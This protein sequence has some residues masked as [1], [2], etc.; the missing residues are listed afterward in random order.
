[1][2]VCCRYNWND[3]RNRGSTGQSW[4]S[5]DEP[6][7]MRAR[8]GQHAGWQLACRFRWVPPLPDTEMNP[9]RSSRTALRA[10]LILSCLA[11][12]GVDAVPRALAQEQQGG[13]T[14]LRGTPAARP[15]EPADPGAA[16]RRAPPQPM[17]LPVGGSTQPAAPR[18]QPVNSGGTIAPSQAAT[19]TVDSIL[20][21]GKPLVDN[22]AAAFRAALQAADEARWDAARALVPREG[23][24]P[25]LVKLIEW[26]SLRSDK[27][28]GTFAQ[29]VSFLRAN[30]D[31]PEESV[32]RRR[33]EDRIGPEV[34][35]AD[36]VAFFATAA[37]Q[38]SA[39]TMKRLAALATVQPATLPAV[40]RQSWRDATFR[41]AD[42]AE[43]L[44]RYGHH[45]EGSDH[46]ARFERFIRESREKPASEM[47]ARLP[48]DYRPVAE[49]RLALLTREENAVT[50]LRGLPAARQRDPGLMLAALRY[51]RR[52]G[53]AKQAAEIARQGGQGE[54]EWWPEREALARDALQAKRAK[55][56]YDIVAVHG[57][58][59][60]GAFAEAEFLAGW[61]ALRHLNNPQLALKHFTALEQGVATPISKSR[62]AYWLGRAYD[63]DKKPAEALAWFDRAAQHGHTYYGQLAAKRLPGG[64]A[65]MPSDPDA[66]DGDRRAIEGR[67][68]MSVV[69]Y[70]RQVGEDERAR[71]FLLRLTRMASGAG[72]IGLTARLALELGR[73]DIAVQLSRNVVEAGIVLFQ[74]SFPVV[75]LSDT[76][77]IER[78]LVLALI[79]QE[80]SFNPKALSPAGALGLM[81]LMPAT[82]RETASRAG[83]PFVQD[84]LTSDPAYNV[85][86]GT[87]HLARLLQKYG[88]SYELAVAAYNGG[89][90]SVDRWLRTIGDPRGGRVDMVDWVEMI[91]FRE[92]RNYVQRVMEGVAVYR[93]RLNGPFD[94]VAIGGR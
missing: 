37:P 34:P 46:I 55:D 26:M 17:T 2:R 92:T 88:G 74:S 6:V 40:V 93:D 41:P 39:G 86:L 18:P 52:T 9:I 89:E 42:E 77:A 72:E 62:A 8:V 11:G 3:L 25:E 20:A 49:V 43:F 73:P 33:A 68:I 75:E 30:P 57:L 36:I 90:G 54:A 4:Q 12:L 19:L 91:G 64:F 29:T 47:L 85:T 44:A 60:G 80:S 15:P 56:A 63:S 79:R 69:R 61:I 50:L 32:L 21:A 45:I 38:T 13:V 58:S 87:V 48:P 35:A 5:C 1:M 27:G 81:Q 24:L 7:R 94:T 10:S 14:V 16:P 67:E 23:G 83:V 76:G 53:E 84:R 66:T 31:W 51:L 65:R 82:A 59:R 78:A 22:D 28:D 71:P 70:L